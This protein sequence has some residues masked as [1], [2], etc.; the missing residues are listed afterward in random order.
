MV[1][2]LPGL[3][4]PLTE[5]IQAFQ[6]VSGNRG[7]HRAIDN[8]WPLAR[9][10]ADLSRVMDSEEESEEGEALPVIKVKKTRAPAARQLKEVDVHVINTPQVSAPLFSWIII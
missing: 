10:I 6:G 9:S 1:G 4:P 3:G 7:I 8:L 5:M 2:S